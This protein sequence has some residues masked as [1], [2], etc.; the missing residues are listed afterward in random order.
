[1]GRRALA[2]PAT[3]VTAG[4]AVSVVAARYYLTCRQRLTNW[5]ATTAETGRTLPGDDLSPDSDLTTTR[6]IAI[7]APSDCVWPWLVQI[8]SGRAGGYSYDWIE[9]LF[10]LDMHSAEVILPQF[11][12]LK[13]GDEFPFGNR[14]VMRAE[15]VQPG[16]TLALG[17]LDGNWVCT[18]AL[19]P[20]S[21]STRLISRNRI[22]LP[23][24]STASRL[25][26][27]L[28]IVPGSLVLERKM[29]NGIKARAERLAAERN[30]GTTPDPSLRTGE[31]L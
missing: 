30:S 21:T 14:G 11:Q 5:G 4:L 17:F 24:S 27:A 7:S 16:R 1:M 25:L 23:T 18:L 19:L 8:G 20:Q 28:V 10:G 9:N 12:D 2:G 15:I 31:Y 3:A 13:Q 26:G 29:L 6:A 22:T